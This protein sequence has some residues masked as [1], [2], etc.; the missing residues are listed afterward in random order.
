MWSN[1]KLL[2]DYSLL[3]QLVMS[4]VYKGNILD[5]QK[6]FDIKTLCFTK[7][8][9]HIRTLSF[10]LKQT[11]LIVEKSGTSDDIN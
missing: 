7:A 8:V 1:R 5:N 4:V 6:I 3:S 9:F 11:I 10:S 2:F